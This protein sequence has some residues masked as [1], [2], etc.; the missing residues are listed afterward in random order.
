M[1]KGAKGKVWFENEFC[2][3]CEAFERHCN[4]ENRAV[5]IEAEKLRLEYDKYEEY[6]KNEGK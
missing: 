6:L 2:C 1:E 5:C 4:G 3:Y